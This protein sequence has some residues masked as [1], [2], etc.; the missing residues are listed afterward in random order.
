MGRVPVPRNDA[1]PWTT[2]LRDPAVRRQLPPRYR[3]YARW[4]L[5]G[6]RRRS[7][8]VAG[9]S[10]LHR[11]LARTDGALGRDTSARIA[12]AGSVL[13]CDLANPRVWV[14][15]DEVAGGTEHAAVLAALL[16]P[17]DA[18]LDVGANHGAYALVAGRHVGDAGRIVAVEPQPELAAR[19][20]ASLAESVRAP[21]AVHQAAC[22]AAPERATFFVPRWKPGSAG[23][24]RAFSG[25][26]EHASFTVDVVPLDALVDADEL[27][28]RVVVKLDV[29]GNELAAL[30]GA[31]RLLERRRPAILLEVNPA[32]ARAAGGTAGAVIAHLRDR[33]YGSA[34]PFA[35]PAR[36]IP[37]AALDTASPGDYVLFHGPPGRPADAPA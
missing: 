22:G 31:E 8:F 29:E 3:L 4:L 14:A 17:G 6:P 1:R 7:G 5:H 19:L 16:E 12:V 18:F 32:S 20:R 13:H 30:R 35:D 25:R 28:E 27:P 9:G 15:L 23:L 26:G 37:I 33:G 10:F 24:H 2:G 11:A 34:A 36:R 21:A